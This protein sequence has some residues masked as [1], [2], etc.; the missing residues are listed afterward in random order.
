VGLPA[1]VTL[2][3]ALSFAALLIGLRV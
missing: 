2:W 3:F 1:V